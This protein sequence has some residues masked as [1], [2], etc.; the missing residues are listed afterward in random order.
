VKP[1]DRSIFVFLAPQRN[2]LTVYL[3][4]SIV[5][6]VKYCTSPT[7]K[8][9]NQ[10]I[11]D[12]QS[13]SECFFF[14]F[15]SVVSPLNLLVGGLEHEFYFSIQLGTIIPDWYLTIQRDITDEPL[16]LVAKWGVPDE[17]KRSGSLVFMFFHPRKLQSRRVI[18]LFHDIPSFSDKLH[19]LDTH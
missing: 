8:G 19:T 9:Y 14:G 1:G 16:G 10:R 15:G 11:M 18:R 12:E 6:C 2:L 4:L 7:I 3:C 17:P 13:S 5:F